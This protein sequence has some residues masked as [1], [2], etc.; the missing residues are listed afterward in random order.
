MFSPEFY[1]GCFSAL[2]IFLSVYKVRLI[3]L[4]PFLFFKEKMY[5]SIIFLKFV[6]SLCKDIM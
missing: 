3:S 6:N 2:L 1:F 5:I 4:Y